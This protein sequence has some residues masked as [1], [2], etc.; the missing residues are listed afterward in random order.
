MKIDLEG[1]RWI[2][3]AQ[4]HNRF[5]LGAFQYFVSQG[6]KFEDVKAAF[7]TLGIHTNIRRTK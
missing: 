4:S 3:R 5:V 7:R 1:R 2:R 6:W